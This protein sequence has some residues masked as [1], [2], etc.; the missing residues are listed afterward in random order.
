MPPRRSAGG[1]LPGGGR[2]AGGGAPAWHGGC[3]PARALA[4][5]RGGR[6]AA[7]APPLPR[8]PRHSAARPAAGHTKRE[9]GAGA[10]PSSDW[11]RIVAAGGGGRGGRE[12]RRGEGGQKA[13]E[14]GMLLWARGYHRSAA[15]AGCQHRPRAIR[16]GTGTLCTFPRPSG[17]Y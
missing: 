4:R 17:G 2:A 13:E 8:P 10:K 12:G 16:G 1:M 6:S 14:V 3:A 7:A 11:V 9:V 5:T 15:G